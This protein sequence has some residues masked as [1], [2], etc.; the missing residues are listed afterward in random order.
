VEESRLAPDGVDG[1]GTHGQPAHVR[2][3]ETGEPTR[4]ELTHDRSRPKTRK[5]SSRSTVTSLPGPQPTS[6]TTAP[7]GRPAVTSATL[8]R[9]SSSMIDVR[10]ANSAV[11]MS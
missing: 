6:T 1:C 7:G 5:P 4:S 11:I 3:D 9:S 10:R 8:E 2:L